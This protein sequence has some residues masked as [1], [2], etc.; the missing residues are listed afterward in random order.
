M[1]AKKDLQ[2][3]FNTITKEAAE[4]SNVLSTTVGAAKQRRL[5]EE[6]LD[7]EITFSL[8]GVE[9]TVDG[10]AAVDLL[11][12][13][14][15]KAD[16]ETKKDP[17]GV[18]GS[19]P[20]ASDSTLGPQLLFRRNQAWLKYRLDAEAA[21]SVESFFDASTSGA[22]ALSWYR[23]HGLAK[24][25][26]TAIL[27]DLSEPRFALVRSHVSALQ[28]DEALTLHVRGK[29]SVGFSFEWSDFFASNLSV[30][31]EM[32]DEDETFSIAADV[33]ATASVRASVE[34]DFILIFTRAS[35]G[36]LRVA[37]KKAKD[38]SFQATAGVSARVR[39]ANPDDVVR[40]VASAKD[41]LIGPHLTQISEIIDSGQ[42]F[43]DLSPTG[44]GLV[45][46][47]RKRLRVVDDARDKVQGLRETVAALDKKLDEEIKY[48]FSAAAPVYTGR[49][50]AW[51]S[52]GAPVRL[53]A[54]VLRWRA[55]TG[56]QRTEA[57]RFMHR[58]CGGR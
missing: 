26:G 6:S 58:T 9:L 38:K 39:F 55:T 50:E 47:V 52:M 54:E 33:G 7:K 56:G 17:D 22:I 44:K 21:A 57:G 31:G 1:P 34:D 18:L 20:E 27:D 23:G 16:H 28:P 10:T 36:R 19:T 45:A 4:I 5:V 12:R 53:A 43:D 30:F 15:F 8:A 29:L 48:S 49:A 25:V 42:E 46:D 37:V 24:N 2:R 41:S 3:A 40:V 32:L 13:H 14:T 35:P 51:W 11:N